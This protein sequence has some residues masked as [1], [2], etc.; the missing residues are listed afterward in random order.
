[1]LMTLGV[2]DLEG[3]DGMESGFSAAGSAGGLAGQ[4]VAS[5]IASYLRDLHQRFA[6][7][8]D[9]TVATYIPELAKA[10]PEWFGICIATTDG[11]VYEV[12]D[13]AQ[14]FTIQ[15]ISKPFVYGLALEDRGRE[16]VL[17]KIGVEPTGDAFNSI[18]LAPGTGRPLNPMINAGAITTTSLIA[19]HSD[20]DKLQR[21]VAVLSTY[22]GRPL[23]IDQAVYESE[24]STGH[25]NRAIG[26]MLRNFDIIEADPEPPL[27]LYF[28]QCSVL[29]NC[30]DLALMAATLANDGVHPCTGERALHHEHIDRVLSVMTTCG[31]YD[32]A[33]EWVYWVGMPAKSGVA[34]GIVAVLPGQLGIGVFSP[35]LDARGN[36]VRGVAVCKELSQSLHLH[37]LRTARSAHSVL[38][39]CNTLAEIGSKRLRPEAER[40]V[41]DR[42]GATVK[43]VELQGDLVFAA[44]ESVVRRLVE[45]S[46]STQI[47]VLDFKKV[48]SLAECAPALMQHL[49]ADYEAAGKQI[50]LVNAQQHHRFLRTLEE[51]LAGGPRW[52]RAVTFDDL[53]RA[54]EWCEN[55]ILE[56]HQ[57]P[58]SSAR[59]LSLAEHQI[60]QGL[61]A[62]EIGVLGR[63]LQHL[64]MAPGDLILRKGDPANG[65]YLLLGGQVSVTVTLPNGQLKRLSTLSAGM[66]F[67]ELAVVDRGTRGADV[68]ADTAVDCALL[69]LEAYDR[70]D[71]EYPAIKMRVLEN[72]LRQLS[73][74]VSRLNQEVR[75]L[76]S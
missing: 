65:F 51:G 19:G 30:R 44:L 52:A 69:S 40:Q 33:G 66:A 61:H 63:H 34:G 71:R 36:S 8:R 37:C 21:L 23:E 3:R 35:R 53:D 64:Q 14:T 62:D 5:P 27:D 56:Q 73:R 32:Y 7:L 22:A 28:Q 11:K 43:V 16:A 10:D 45:A 24:R 70:L 38:R 54:I 50:V 74:T 60:C 12:G 76:S 39:S 6:G 41:L 25:R 72:L 17:A 55:Q 75:A 29:V 1:M 15:S 18:S 46:P 4:G 57:S 31:M 59:R 68:S 9:G 20:T 47:A 49:V 67:G 58:P 13:S 42:F 2:S 26:H 48:T